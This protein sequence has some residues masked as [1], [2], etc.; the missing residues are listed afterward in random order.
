MFL[1]CA[2]ALYGQF[3]AKFPTYV[4]RASHSYISPR[5]KLVLAACVLT[6]FALSGIVSLLDYTVLRKTSLVVRDKDGDIHV[7]VG[8]K[9]G[10]SH[11]WM[12]FRRG[13][14][15]EEFKVELDKLFEVEGVLLQTPTLNVFE[16]NLSAFLS[17]KDKKKD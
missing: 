5:D 14:K 17:K 13:A 4:F 10:Q 1:A 9:K 16:A 2:A 8:M 12:S 15:E 3:G 11:A 7:G 6:Y